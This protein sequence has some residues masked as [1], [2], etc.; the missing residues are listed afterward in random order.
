MPQAKY[1]RFTI[2]C[3]NRGSLDDALLINTDKTKQKLLKSSVNFL[4][5]QGYECGQAYENP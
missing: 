1:I 3:K 2:S 5:I 4:S